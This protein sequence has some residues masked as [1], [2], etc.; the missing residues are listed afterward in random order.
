MKMQ[1]S[2]QTQD[3]FPI[4]PSKQDIF[5]SVAC[6]QSRKIEDYFSSTCLDCRKGLISGDPKKGPDTICYR[7]ISKRQIEMIQTLL[8]G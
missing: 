6:K 4:F 1:S 2:F 5:A 8:C 7:K 3:S